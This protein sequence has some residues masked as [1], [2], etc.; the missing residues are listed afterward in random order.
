[1][2]DINIDMHEIEQPQKKRRAPYGTDRSAKLRSR[3]RRR[4]KITTARAGGNRARRE[5]HER[6][7]AHYDAMARQ[8]EEREA[9]EAQKR[10]K[11]AAA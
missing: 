3:R 4:S 6:V 9:A 1:M 11:G 8:R 5:E 2:F 7:I 10:A